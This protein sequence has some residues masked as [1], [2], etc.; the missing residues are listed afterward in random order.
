M[1]SKFGTASIAQCHLRRIRELDIAAESTDSA[2][3]AIPASLTDRDL[4]ILDPRAS[5]EGNHEIAR[6]LSI[7]TNTVGSHIASILLPSSTSRTA[8]KQPCKQ[9]GVTSRDRD[10]GARDRSRGLGKRWASKMPRGAERRCV[11]G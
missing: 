1:S 7:S 6:E 4:E 10:L 8:S 11:S 3:V 5:G 9:C 2:A